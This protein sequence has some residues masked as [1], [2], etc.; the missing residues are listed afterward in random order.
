MSFTPE[1]SAQVGAD[2]AVTFRYGDGDLLI[3]DSGE[4]ALQ[5]RPEIAL[6]IADAVQAIAAEV[7]DAERRLAWLASAPPA[8][9]ALWRQYPYWHVPARTEIGPLGR[10]SC[11]I[12]GA[13]FEAVIRALDLEDRFLH[14]GGSAHRGADYAGITFL[15]H[16]LVEG[17]AVTA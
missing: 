17:R 7:M 16:E 13:T 2:G 5:L 11:H 3:D 10:I 1:L 6:A 9:A 12:D 4:N 14:M 8:L 15:T